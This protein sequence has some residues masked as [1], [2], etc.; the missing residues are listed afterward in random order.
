MIR[1]TELPLI[2]FNVILL[3]DKQYDEAGLLLTKRVSKMVGERD[4]K[5]KSVFVCVCGSEVRSER[6][7][8]GEINR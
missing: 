4:R 3:R 2:L 1:R 7:S 6:E 5:R 8:K